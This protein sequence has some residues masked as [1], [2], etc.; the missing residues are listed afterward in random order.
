MPFY[1]QSIKRRNM[2]IKE[3]LFAPRLDHRG[4]STPS[5]ASRLFFI[6]AM[7]G[8]GIWSWDLSESNIVV[9]LC[10]LMLTSTPLLSFGWWLISLVSKGIEPRVLIESVNNLDK[11][12]KI[13]LHSFRKP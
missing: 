7:I 13:P 9:F 5:E 4:W 2:G 11:S 3:Y 12:K 6:I 10:L 1:Y 8:C